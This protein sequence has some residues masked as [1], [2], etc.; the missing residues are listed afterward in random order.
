M[1]VSPVAI[2]PRF[3]SRGPPGAA[4]HKNRREMVFI[5][6]TPH[7]LNLFNENGEQVA[8]IPPSGLIA[9]VSTERVMVEKKGG[10][11]FFRT[12]YGEVDGLPGPQ[13]DTIYVVSG[14]VRAAV[15]HRE[16][17]WQP[18]ELLRDENG[19]VIGAVGLTR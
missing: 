3:F 8:Q 5:N 1:D 13:A 18:G 4:H 7:T 6:L 14:F 9:R 2:R 19:R 15:P 17:V 16:D 11:P 12:E 10:I